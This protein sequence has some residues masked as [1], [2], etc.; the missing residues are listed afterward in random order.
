MTYIPDDLSDLTLDELTNHYETLKAQVAAHSCKHSTL[1]IVKKSRKNINGAD[2][3]QYI[4]QCMICGSQ[5][6]Q[7]MKREAAL[8]NNNNVEP[9]L[10][11]ADLENIFI[12]KDA[13]Y[14][15]I[16]TEITIR[17]ET[18]DDQ[19]R[20]WSLNNKLA[21]ED[22]KREKF[23]KYLFDAS[24]EFG[25]NFIQILHN[26]IT[27]FSKKPSQHSS[28]KELLENDTLK[29]KEEALKV[30]FKEHFK[31]IFEIQEEVWGICDY[32]QTSI[33]I[34]FL[35]KL[36]EKAKESISKSIPDFEDI[37]LFGVEVKY[38][39]LEHDTANNLSEA[40]AQCIDY[41][42]SKFKLE[43]QTTYLPFILL[44]S[45]LSF[46]KENERLSQVYNLKYRAK[47]ALTS[48]RTI[49]RKF[50]IGEFSFTTYPESLRLKGWRINFLDQTY[51]KS[52]IFNNKEKYSQGIHSLARKIGN[53]SAK[54]R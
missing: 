20:A 32:K 38:F 42:F 47:T 13:L 51:L 41:S 3:Y 19:I 12:S 50:N 25:S 29:N 10:Y 11:N 17:T 30:W 28:I 16:M 52:E 7:A 22:K 54:P 45:N 18:E 49:A 26:F 34:D 53:R 46:D 31:H 8:I 15:K 43:S 9:D 39:D 33:R 35:L 48:T 1:K 27:T 37:G 40:Y 24:L 23:E 2:S 44:L 6:E 21:I 14:K 36:T 5:K 4:K